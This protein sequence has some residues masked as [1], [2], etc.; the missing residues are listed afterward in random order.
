[1]RRCQLVSG[2]HRTGCFHK[3][4]ALYADSDFTTQEAASRPWAHSVGFAFA[5]GWRRASAGFLSTILAAAAD[6]DT[7]AKVFC[8]RSIYSMGLAVP[9]CLLHWH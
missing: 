7:V 3:I 8:C 6:A 1:M 9:F 2:L 5:F 4:K